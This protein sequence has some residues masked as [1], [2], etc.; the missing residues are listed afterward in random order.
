[1]R[2]DQN[3]RPPTV[4]HLHGVEYTDYGR[5]YAH[6]PS[7]RVVDMI[8]N[9]RSDIGNVPYAGLH[10]A[11]GIF[12]APRLYTPNAEAQRHEL[13]YRYYEDRRRNILSRLLAAQRVELDIILAY[14]LPGLNAPRTLHSSEQ[15]FRRK[16]A[17]PYS[18][19]YRHVFD[20]MGLFHSWALRPEL[21]LGQLI[22]L[23]LLGR[24]DRIADIREMAEWIIQC[25][26][27]FYSRAYVD[28]EGDATGRPVT[29]EDH[30]RAYLRQHSQHFDSIFSP[31]DSASRRRGQAYANNNANEVRYLPPGAENFVFRDFFAEPVNQMTMRPL[32][33][34]PSLNPTPLHQFNML[35]QIQREVLRHAVVFSGTINEIYV[36]GQWITLPREVFDVAEFHGLA[37]PPPGQSLFGRP[38]QQPKKRKREDTE[39][40]AT[41]SKQPKLDT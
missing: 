6:L 18:F 8:G 38:G 40:D 32:P 39:E 24:D 19:L 35:A 28:W 33:W 1:M 7:D 41:P 13:V 22:T 2:P 30:I 26:P 34:A 31:V 27:W 12:S 36:P 14:Y 4:Q 10:S 25:Y 21:N 16:L 37:N 3:F 23:A 20:T 15:P 11:L 17:R 5:A 29:L 9:A